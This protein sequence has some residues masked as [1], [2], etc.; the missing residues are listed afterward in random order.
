MNNED[1]P[2]RIIEKVQEKIAIFELKKEERKM[3]INSK[4]LVN[5]AATAILVTGLS[6]GTVYAGTVIY[7]KI[8][9]EPTRIDM[10]EESYKITDE[11][12]KENISEEEAKKVAQDKLI[13]IGLENKEIIGTDHYKY[14]GTEELY[15]RFVIN[16]GLIT[17]NGQTGEFSNLNLSP[18][19]RSVENYTMSKEEAIE[20]GREYYNKF[21]YQEAE[22]E[23]AEVSPMGNGENYTAMF[24]KKYGDLYNK[25]EYVCISFYAKDH[26]LSGYSV[27]NSKC[28]NNPVK[29]TKEEA[30]EIAIN[31]DRKVESKPIIRTDAEL[32]IKGMNGNAYAR[33]NN[34][35]EYYKP[36]T[37]TDVPIEEIV[38]YKT[39]GRVRTVWVVVLKYSDENTDIVERIAKGQYSYYVDA[40]TGEIIGGQSSDDLTSENYWFEQ[41][42]VN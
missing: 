1:L 19:D 30:I 10:S 41:N 39:E 35:E 16:N 33:L 4:R 42:K 22:Y 40:T 31:E 37:T 29:I 13:Q 15:Y 24:Y 28:E 38:K 25:G 14:P 20:V 18:Q 36:M 17:I 21:G 8:W 7:E 3:K 32:R 6:I 9:K 2:N 11:T 5:I 27:G 26:Q 12:I 34:T 23:F